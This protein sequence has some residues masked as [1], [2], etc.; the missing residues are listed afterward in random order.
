[1]ERLEGKR[2]RWLGWDYRVWRGTEELTVIDVGA[3]RSRG[4]FV[5]AGERYALRRAGIVT[6]VFVLAL[7]L[8]RWRKRARSRS[9]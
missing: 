7:V 9:G 5:L 1:V 3:L 2:V 6:Q 4:E 8:L